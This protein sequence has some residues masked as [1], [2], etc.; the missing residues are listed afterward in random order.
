M[1][2]DGPSRCTTK[3][4]LGGVE[5]PQTIKLLLV[6]VSKAIFVLKQHSIT[7]NL[8]IDTHLKTLPL[9]TMMSLQANWQ[10]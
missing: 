2:T 1:I 10:F 6:D 3:I 5:V 8:Y 7:R 4:P 9:M